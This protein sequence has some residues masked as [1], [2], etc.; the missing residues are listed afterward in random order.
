MKNIIIASILM[1]LASCGFSPVYGEKNVN[2]KLSGVKASITPVGDI[3]EKFLQKFKRD[4]EDVLH[5]N[6]SDAKITHSLDIS[7]VKTVASYST[8]NNTDTRSRITLIASIS[9]KD[10]N[11]EKVVYRDRIMSIDS[12]QVAD[13]PYSA[14]VT[15]EETLNRMTKELANEIGLR[16]LRNFGV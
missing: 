14:L 1:L 5:T 10:L 11:T 3:P 12:F 8:Q 13:S 6:Q 7:V 2:H 9:V 16:L 4:L 15:E